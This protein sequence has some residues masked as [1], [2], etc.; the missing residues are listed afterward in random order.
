MKTAAAQGI[1]ELTREAALDF[2]H[3]L[4]QHV[5]VAR[6]ELTAEL[7]AMIRRARMIVVLSTLFAIGYALTMAGLAVVLGGHTPVG[8]P[9]VVIGLGHMAAAG[10]G[11]LLTPSR[12][13]GSH[14][15]NRSTTAMAR[16]IEALEEATEPSVEKTDDNRHEIERG[17]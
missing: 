8:L 14:L 2:G 9:L 6:L 5:K 10:V 16:S 17:H 13:L 15:M 3:L 12:K 7:H 11:L 1:S 4:G